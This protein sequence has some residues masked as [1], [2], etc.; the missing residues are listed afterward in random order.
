MSRA[1]SVV[2]ANVS[3]TSPSCSGNIS[4][5]AFFPRHC[6][7]TS[8]YRNNC[9]GREQPMLYKRHGALLLAT[10]GF[11][12]S[13]FSSAA[14]MRSAAA[15]TPR[16]ISSHSEVARVLAVFE[17]AKG[18]PAEWPC[19]NKQRHIGATPRTVQ[20]EN[21]RPCGMRKMCCTNAP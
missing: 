19:E 10:S 8:M 21:R 9:T 16:A 20:R 1:K 4:V 11:D 6:S 13:K 2:S 14:A 7:S 15:I 3:G 5:F 17:Q 12:A 18:S